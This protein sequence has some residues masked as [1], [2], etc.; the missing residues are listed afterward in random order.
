MFLEQATCIV[1]M[2][3]EQATCIANIMYCKHVL[4]K[5]NVSFRV[6][7]DNILEG[8]VIREQGTGKY[9]L[10]STF[11]IIYFTRFLESFQLP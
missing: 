8:E 4:K 7:I 2:F 11:M 6:R 1:N 3:L 9:I 5:L 10:F